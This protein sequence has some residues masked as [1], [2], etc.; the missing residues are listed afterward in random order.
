MAEETKYESPAAE[1]AALRAKREAREAARAHEFEG[2]ELV[3]ERLRDRFEDELGP[4]GRE[5]AV[6]DLR[7]LGEG[8]FVVKRPDGL[9][10]K[11]W[12]TAVNKANSKERAIDEAEYAGYVADNIVHPTR[13]AY[14]DVAGRRQIVHARCAKA[15]MDLSGARREEREG[16]Y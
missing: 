12:M 4:E 2:Q 6:V 3:L 9:A 16:K 15:L 5:F 10:H 11:R 14:L 13:A 8:I 7:E 1:L